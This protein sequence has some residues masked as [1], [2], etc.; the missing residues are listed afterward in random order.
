MLMGSETEFGILG[1]WTH[2]AASAIQQRVEASFTHLPATKEGV[3]LANGGRAYVDLECH[4]EYGTPEVEDPLSLV[5][6]ELAG[7]ALMRAA[8]AADGHVLV[9]SNVDYLS[10]HSWGTHENYECRK[11]LDA[12]ASAA[13]QSHLATRIVFS[14]AGGPHPVSPGMRFVLSPRAAITRARRGTQGTTIKAMLYRKPEHHGAGH[15][16]HVF[17]GKSLL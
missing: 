17:C 14:G 6:H 9:C 12:A 16:L 7:R 4:N 13:M 1:G 11:P 15:R 2:T 8:A 3:F 5:R 10:L